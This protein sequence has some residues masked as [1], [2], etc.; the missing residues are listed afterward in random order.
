MSSKYTLR[1]ALNL[2]PMQLS[3]PEGHDYCSYWQPKEGDE[4]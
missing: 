1:S 4:R 2:T 3:N